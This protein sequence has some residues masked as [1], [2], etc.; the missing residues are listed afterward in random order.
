MVISFQNRGVNMFDN[1]FVDNY[2]QREEKENYI[3][4][5]LINTL[6]C[7]TD[8]NQSECYSIIKKFKEKILGNVEL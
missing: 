3:V 2:L 4:K 8:V 1:N 7:G 6:Y 5:C